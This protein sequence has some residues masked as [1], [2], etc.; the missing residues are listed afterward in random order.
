MRSTA[1]TTSPSIVSFVPELGFEM[2]NAFITVLLAQGNLLRRH[3]RLRFRKRHGD[4]IL[5]S[6][7]LKFFQTIDLKSLLVLDIRLTFLV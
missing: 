5:T 6:A 3:M 7:H 2:I 1:P 4:S